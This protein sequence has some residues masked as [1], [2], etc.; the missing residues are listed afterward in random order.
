VD[1]RVLLGV[2]DELLFGL[3][4][5][6]VTATGARIHFGAINNFSHFSASIFNE[7]RQAAM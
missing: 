1:L 2:P 7:L 3:A 4:S 5:N 6:Y